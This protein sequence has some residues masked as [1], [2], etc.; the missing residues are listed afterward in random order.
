M[1]VA[2]GRWTP[3]EGSAM[4]AEGSWRIRPLAES[5]LPEVAR[6]DAFHTGIEKPQYW[7]RMFRTLVTAGDDVV[8]IGV[9][10]EAD[11]GL[12]GYLV[13]EIRAFEFGSD[14]CGWIVAVGVDERYLH[15]RV[16]SSLVR[17]ASAR[18]REAGVTRV[19]T[20]VLRN[21]V[22]VLS[23]FRSNGF[24]GGAYVQLELELDEEDDQGTA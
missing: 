20:M 13:G 10:A 21:D 12:A 8:R 19:R 18:F 4:T 23:F 22:P 9:A 6:I 17:E 15:T 3:V 24:A 11:H 14:A 2:P 7:T 5:D 16:G 1:S